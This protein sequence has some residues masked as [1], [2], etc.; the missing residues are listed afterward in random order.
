M[1]SG[2]P[3]RMAT[4]P[5]SIPSIT[6]GGFV[7]AM[8]AAWCADN[9]SP[10]E[11]PEPLDVVEMPGAAQERKVVL[12]AQGCKPDIVRRDRRSSA[13]QFEANLCVFGHGF[14]RNIERIA[15]R[16]DPRKPFFVFVA[17]IGLRNPVTIF[18]Y[19]N[20][21]D[22]DLIGFAHRS[23]SL[24]GIVRETGQRVRVH[25]QSQSSGS[26]RPNSSSISF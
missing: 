24:R 21:G 9:P 17:A 20:D 5:A 26:M 22:R 14:H 1:R 23:D 10:G 12:A 4:I 8:R 13:S 3:G 19:D 16:Q 7:L 2:F 15:G 6:S 11:A 25:D 18:A